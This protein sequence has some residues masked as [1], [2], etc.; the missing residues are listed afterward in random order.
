MH[1]HF[2]VGAK[3]SLWIEWIVSSK[4]GELSVFHL[5]NIMWAE[6]RDQLLLDESEIVITWSLLLGGGGEAG[7]ERAIYTS[8][9]NQVKIVFVI[10]W[11]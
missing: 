2:W 8:Q 11:V 6:A 1:T 9:K 4:Q 3:H 10:R 5:E 7:R